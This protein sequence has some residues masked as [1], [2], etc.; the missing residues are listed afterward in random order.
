MRRRERDAKRVAKSVRTHEKTMAALGKA[1]G[2]TRTEPA[3]TGPYETVSY[4]GNINTRETFSPGAVKING[5]EHDSG[6]SRKHNTSYR[7]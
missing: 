2:W 1:A 5:V 3:N 4:A 7:E 6:V